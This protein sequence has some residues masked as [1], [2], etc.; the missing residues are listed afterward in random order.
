MF[1][2]PA[3]TSHGLYI[4]P[5]IYESGCPAH[6]GCPIRKSRDYRLFDTCPGLIA[7]YYVLL[8]LLTPRHPP[9]TLNNLTISIV[10]CM[11]ALYNHVYRPN[12]GRV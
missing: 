3:L 2:F 4:Q 1:Q 12:Y 11:V 6:M 9:Y 8:R 7:V 10:D 5:W